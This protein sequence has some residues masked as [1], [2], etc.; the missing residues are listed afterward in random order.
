MTFHCSLIGTK[1][2]FWGKIDNKW[3]LCANVPLNPYFG[4]E[5]SKRQV[6]QVLAKSLLTKFHIVG[7]GSFHVISRP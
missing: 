5:L 3:P 4:N 7:T 2:H 1:C 6:G